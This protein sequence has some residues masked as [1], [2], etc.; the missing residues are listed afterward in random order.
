MKNP[1]SIAHTVN[2]QFYLYKRQH[3][4]ALSE[5]QHA[6]RLDPNDP[7]ANT[8]MGY[9]LLFMGRGREAVEYIKTAMRLDPQQNPSFYLSRLGR[10]GESAREGDEVK[11]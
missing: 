1:T 3:E 8:L 7:A 5:M 10:G 9:T 2:S 11:S 6:L 4:E